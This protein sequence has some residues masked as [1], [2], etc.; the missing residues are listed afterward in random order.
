MR[1]RAFGSTGLRV[2]E[3]GL[4]AYPISG[5][6][7]NPDG[8]PFGW[9][10]VEDRESI[11]LI[12][13]AEELGV[14]LVDSA[15]GY[16]EGHSE[17]V[18]G[19]ALRNR[20]QKW[21]VATKVQP[22]RGLA[23]DI[24]D[25]AAA[26]RRIVEACEQ[27]LRRLRMETIDLYQL[28]AIPHA[29][30]SEPVM[31]ALAQLKAQGKVLFY[32]ISTNDLSAVQRLRQYGPID[33]LQIGYNLLERSADAMLHWAREHGIG[34]LIRVPLAKGML[35][36]KYSG[37]GGADR[38]P[39][40]DLRYDRLHRPEVAESLE[41]LEQLSFLAGGTGRTMPQAAL[42][43]VLQHPGVS[44]VIAGAKN[45]QQIEENAAACDVPPVEGAELERALA[46]AE[47]IHT[48]NWI[49]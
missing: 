20:R 40:G 41:R 10:G 35:T 43:F 16:G 39:K 13:R 34:T 48:P 27:S 23:A 7:Q 18:I 28:H 38:L 1:Y 31:T 2:S 9:T 29:W 5:M 30:A 22:N 17:N 19:A 12:H 14:N 26:Q 11:A 6:W 4:G 8:S 47:T 24:P 37:K 49:G 44:C 42:R 32:G 46:I 25:E 36:G 21:I 33:V 15:E 3:I 45:R